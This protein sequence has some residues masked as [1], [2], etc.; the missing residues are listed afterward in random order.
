MIVLNA[1][2]LSLSLCPDVGGT[3]SALT[4]K[5]ADLLRAAP[6]D[7]D[8]LNPREMAAFPMVP[9][10]GR[11]PHG[12]FS[13]RGRRVRLPAN[14]SPEPHAIH[15]FGWQSNWQV[16]AAEKNSATLRHSSEET[17]WPWLYEAFQVFKLE[18]R[19]LEYSLRLNNKS[20]QPMPAG[21]GWHP[22]FPSQNATLFAQTKSEARLPHSL[23]PLSSATETATMQLREGCTVS[24]LSI[25]NVF[26]LS[27]PTIVARW[28]TH[29][30]T[31]ESDPPSRFATIYSPPAS[32]FF[33]A[34]PVTHIPGAHAI[35]DPLF[36]TGLVELQPGEEMRLMIE[37]HLRENDP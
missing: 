34:E 7:S 37:L 26:E 15:G 5:G 30:L 23:E 33:C 31:L 29:T 21:L 16:S 32:E 28:P 14:M 22:Y 35:A 13:W 3:V 27:D 36:E 25:D 9:F 11:I 10:V 2:D 12:E 18:H 17:D 1:G 8:N 24:A 6:A 20:E 19:K 4:W